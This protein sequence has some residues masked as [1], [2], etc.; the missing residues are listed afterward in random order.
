[1]I[2]LTFDD[3]SECIGY[4]TN[5]EIVLNQTPSLGYDKTWKY[6]PY[7]EG[8]NVQYANLYCNGKDFSEVCPD[9]LKAKWE[10][11]N[12]KFKAFI[13]SFIESK[14]SLEEHC[15]Y[16]LVPKQF[17]LE[18]FDIKC[19]IIKHVFDTYEKPHDYDFKL[20]LEKLL[21]EIRY[22]KLKLNQNNIKD[23]LIN[24]NI[25]NFYKKIPTLNPKIDY[26]QFSSKTGRLTTNE[27][28]FPILTLNK[29]YR[30]IIEPNNDFFL[31]MDYNAAEVRTFLA[32]S[33]ESQPDVDIHQ[34]NKD[35]F[36]YESR[37]MVKK[38]FIAWMYGSQ[39]KKFDKFKEIYNVDKIKNSWDGTSVTS[40]FGKVIESDSNH[41]V[42]YAVQSSTAGLVFR[43]AI[44]VNEFLKNNNM[45][46]KIVMLIHDSIV[47]DMK[48]EEKDKIKEIIKLY[49][50]TMFGDYLTSV[51]IGKNFGDMR[52]IEL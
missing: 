35:K 6:L 4:Y 29:E 2:F 30:N 10:Y 49:S 52:K 51:K 38:D 34:W 44:K 19:D 37:D 28:S 42:N 15:F 17:L 26:N 22:N 39:D 13:R 50:N 5:G 21:T 33:G 31:E 1:M 43:Q 8:K 40:R 36:N 48:K 14:V 11:N 41:V 32:L 16:D 20:S 23:K 18:Y 7:L 9:K 27:G 46:S 47:L 3:K 24:S 12:N 25:R 45:K